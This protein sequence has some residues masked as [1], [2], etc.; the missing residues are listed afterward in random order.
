MFVKINNRIL[1]YKEYS[2]DLKKT[3]DLLRE[4]LT[5][6]CSIYGFEEKKDYLLNE[7]LNL[8][9]KL[10]FKTINFLKKI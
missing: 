6:I 7:D 10:E 8:A 5:K 2:E 9:V 4:E 1:D 3:K